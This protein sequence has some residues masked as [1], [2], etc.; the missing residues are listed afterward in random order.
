MY[1]RGSQIDPSINYLTFDAEITS[2]SF[3]RGFL[4]NKPSRIATVKGIDIY[5]YKRMQSEGMHYYFASFESNQATI[6]PYRPITFYCHL[7]VTSQRNGLFKQGCG[8]HTATIW[9]SKYDPDIPSNFGLT[10]FN[11]V[12]LRYINKMFVTDK[13]KSISGNIVTKAIMR[14]LTYRDWQLY[15][16]LSDKEKYV[17]PVTYAQY[18]AKIQTVQGLGRGY[19][20]RCVFALKNDDLD[21]V[22]NRDVQVVSFKD[23]CRLNLFNA[24]VWNSDLER[25]DESEYSLYQD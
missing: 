1:I 20:Y 2:K 21:S 5:M 9:K 13:I 11:T 18:L 23:A 24:P 8:L 19:R 16:G 12:I 25:I 15:L 14:V 17:I 3:V 7:G 4:K 6:Y 10:V 22:I